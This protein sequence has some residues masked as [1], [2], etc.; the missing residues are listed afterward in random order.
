[1]H[2]SNPYPLI[3]LLHAEAK[4]APLNAQLSKLVTAFHSYLKVPRYLAPL[5]LKELRVLFY[6]FYRDLTAIALSIFAKSNS[7]KK[8]LIA[9]SALF[10]ENAMVFDYLVAISNYSSSSIR[11]SRRLDAHAL[12]QLRVFNFYK[13]VTIQESVEAAQRELFLSTTTTEDASLYDKLLRFSEEDIVFQEFLEEKLMVLRDLKLPFSFFS[14]DPHAPKPDDALLKRFQ[15][16]ELCTQEDIEPFSALLNEFSKVS[17]TPAAKISTISKIHKALVTLLL[18]KGFASK[19]L[20]NDLLLPL[21]IYMIINYFDASN[22]LFLG[23]NFIRNFSP[24]ADPYNIPV[25]PV[26][27]SSSYNPADGDTAAA[28]APSSIFSQLNLGADSISIASTEKSNLTVPQEYRF[29][30]NDRELVDF[31]TEQYYY[32]GEEK[33]YLTNLEAALHFLANITS[34]DIQ[35]HDLAPAPDRVILSHHLLQEPVA[36]LREKE[37]A[38]HFRLPTGKLDEELNIPDQDT[39]SQNRLRSLSVLNAITAKFGEARSRSNSGFSKTDDRSSSSLSKEAFP[40][41][42]DEPNLSSNSDDNSGAALVRN[43]LGRISSLMMVPNVTA[44][45]TPKVEDT[46]DASPPQKSSSH[47]RGSSLSFEVNPFFN[48]S[49]SNGLTAKHRNTISSK[50]SSGMSDF[51]TKITAPALSSSPLLSLGRSHS[52][53]S[54]Q[55]LGTHHSIDG[56]ATTLHP[57]NYAGHGSNSVRPSP[58]RELAENGRARTTSLQIMD[59][60]LGTIGGGAPV[61]DKNPSFVEQSHVAATK[62]STDLA[63]YLDMEFEDM[64]IQDLR[65]LKMAYDEICRELITKDVIVPVGS[66][67]NSSNPSEEVKY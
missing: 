5:T 12:Y 34:K 8:L 18:A 67:D 2:G 47:M 30:E 49:S 7:S 57:E 56:S 36:E 32:N 37:L 48:N 63:K 61:S 50:L 54:L 45:T 21:L 19:D 66:E 38:L 65:S 42:T 13:F 52:Q 33:Y 27:V 40:T 44:N 15:S 3:G 17:I 64:T 29:F 1:M 60:W 11:L 6:R 35:E 28:A 59:K 46:C 62:S 41:S 24:S 55:L 9:S 23:L 53:V 39:K 16:I 58:L 26:S 14:A 25:Y 51:M 43:L 22:D 31:I 10:N 20:N 4:L